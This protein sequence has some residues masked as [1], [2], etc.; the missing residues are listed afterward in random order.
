MDMKIAL[1]MMW[2]RRL[3]MKNMRLK[4]FI[5]RITKTIITLTEHKVSLL[6]E[7]YIYFTLSFDRK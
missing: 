6:V 5:S 7:Y 1:K 4:I 3:S 2:W